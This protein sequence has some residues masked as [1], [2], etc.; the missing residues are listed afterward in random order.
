MS[1]EDKLVLD[2]MAML[3]PLPLGIKLKLLTLLS[4]SIASDYTAAKEEKN[5]S[6]KTLFGAWKDTEE[7]LAE[8]I[9]SARFSNRDIP[10]F[11]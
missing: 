6:W 3:R 2:Y 8:Q 7:N 1:V 9:R 10:S 11:D 5:D 4:E